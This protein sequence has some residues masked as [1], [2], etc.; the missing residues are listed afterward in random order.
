MLAVAQCAGR[1][2]V[3]AEAASE[4]RLLLGSVHACGMLVVIVAHE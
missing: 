3:L 4:V 2:R 1:P